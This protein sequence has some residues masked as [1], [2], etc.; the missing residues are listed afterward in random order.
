[1][2]EATTSTHE[3]QFGPRIEVIHNTKEYLDFIAQ[4][5]RLCVVKFYAS[6]CKSCQK[7]GVLYKRLATQCGDLYET[8]SSLSE[9]HHHDQSQLLK[10]GNV[11]FAEVEFGANA[12]LCRSLGIKK[13]PNVHIYKGTE[14][15]RITGFPCGP[16]KFGMLE[17]TLQ[18]FR[19][20]SDDDL[21]LEKT[22]EE[23]GELVDQILQTLHKERDNGGG[24]AA[25]VKA[26]GNQQQQQQ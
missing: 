6:W 22:L 13:L 3:I 12:E 19:T 10:R 7:F 23:G 17:D 16:S 9:K 21:K 8:T 24:T 14:L 11:R 5:D 26:N 4:D 20:M 15:G 18:R 25:A 1:M 2:T